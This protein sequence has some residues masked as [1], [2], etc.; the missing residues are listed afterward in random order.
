MTQTHRQALPKG[1]RL[2]EYQ[3][4]RVLG[5]GGF[6]LTYLGWDT[7]LDKPVAIKEYLPNDLAVRET[8]HSVM[9]KSH[10][11]EDNFQWGLERFLDEARTLARFKHPNIIDCRSDFNKG[12]EVSG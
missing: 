1:Y 3:L 12:V 6:G 7:S 4:D 8:D 11:D 9:P 10:G 2:H 5:A